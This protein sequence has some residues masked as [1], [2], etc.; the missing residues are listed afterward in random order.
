MQGNHNVIK[1]VKPKRYS[2]EEQQERIEANKKK[3]N[4]HKERIEF[5]EVEEIHWVVSNK[6][7]F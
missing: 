2:F 6:I 1:T 4:K 3:S 5:L 7:V